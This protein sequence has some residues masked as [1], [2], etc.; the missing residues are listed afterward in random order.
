MHNIP[1]TAL[2]LNLNKRK[3]YI[4]QGTKIITSNLIFLLNLTNEIYYLCFTDCQLWLKN[5]SEEIVWR[6]FPRRDCICW[7]PGPSSDHGLV[8]DVT[9]L[10]VPCFRGYLYFS[11][12]NTTLQHQHI[13]GHRQTRICGKLEELSESDRHIYFPPSHTPPFLHIYGNPVFTL[14]Y[15]LVDYCYNVTFTSRNGSFDLTSPKNDLQCT[16]KIYLPYGHRI[17]LTLSI[18][19]NSRSTSIPNTSTELQNSED[20]ECNGLLFELHDGD[21]ARSHCTRSGDIERQIEFVSH[22][23]KVILKVLVRN[24][25]GNTLG[26]KMRYRAEPVEDLVKTCDFGWVAYRQFCLVAMEETRLPWMQAEMECGRKGGHLA[27]IRSSEAQ[28]IIDKMLL[29]R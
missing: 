1:V 22:E 5:E 4:K 12:L 3:A 17:A 11:G 27:S 23:N 9:R 18:G 6:E 28:D 24:T 7:F 29:N 21:N 10:N 16:F 19:D 15:H 8:I 25:D 20:T 2:L 14:N 13:R 26:M